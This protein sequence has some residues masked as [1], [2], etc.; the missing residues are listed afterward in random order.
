MHVTLAHASGQQ[1]ALNFRHYSAE[2]I[3]MR[4]LARQLTSQT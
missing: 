3:G 2:A 4:R 1:E